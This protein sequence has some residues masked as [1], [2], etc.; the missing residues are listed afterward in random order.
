MQLDGGILKFTKILNFSSVCKVFVPKVGKLFLSRNLIDNPKYCENENNSEENFNLRVRE[1]KEHLKLLKR[2]H[3]HELRK[4]N[5]QMHPYTTLHF[6]DTFVLDATKIDE[7]IE[8]YSGN[9][10]T[11]PEAGAGHNINLSDV[12]PLNFTRPDIRSHRAC[13]G[14]RGVTELPSVRNVLGHS[15]QSTVNYRKFFFP[16]FLSPSLKEKYNSWWMVVGV[17]VKD[18]NSSS[19]SWREQKLSVLSLQFGM[20]GH[21]FV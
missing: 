21:Q 1:Y 10:S 4:R 7:F 14:L 12:L 16:S 18:H 3:K 20:I 2:K 13:Q 9:L 11:F 6:H 5:V 8:N 17:E 15:H 19:V